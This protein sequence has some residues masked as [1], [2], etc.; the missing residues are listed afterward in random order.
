MPW[1]H[2]N[3]TLEE[4]V[5]FVGARE[6]AWE[7]GED[8]AFALVDESSGAYLGGAGINQVQRQHAF[9]N[10]GYWVRRSHWGKGIA[11]AAVREV[12]RFAFEQLHLVRLEIVIA[13]GNTKSVRVAEK[14]GAVHEGVLRNR[15]QIAGNFMDAHM[16]SLVEPPCLGIR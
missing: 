9:A 14:A 16:F 1:C 2:D 11:V 13:L 5:E 8:F 6:A 15:L 3:Y 4:S 12:A 7:K 10:L